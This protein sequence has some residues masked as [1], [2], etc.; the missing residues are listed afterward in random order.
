MIK[1]RVL[2]VLSASMLITTTLMAQDNRRKVDLPPM[3]Q[4]HMKTNMRDHL[5]AIQQITDHLSKQQYEEAS[6]VAENRL[7]MSSMGQHGAPQMGKLM[8][9]EMRALGQAM[10]RS[11]SQFAR[12]AKDAEL[13]GGLEKAFGALSEVMQRCVSCHVVYRIQ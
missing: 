6:D 10:H 12:I 7:G 1:N 4:E 9:P 3:M 8:P 13:E 5:L 11:A 2:I